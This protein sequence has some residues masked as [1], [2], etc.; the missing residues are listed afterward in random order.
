MKEKER[1]FLSLIDQGLIQVIPETGEIISYLSGKSRTLNSK[2]SNGY[3]TVSVHKR[4]MLSH[5]LVWLAVH[6]DLQTGYEINHKNGIKGDDRISN[7]E[8]VTR[9]ENV[10]HAYN[11]LGKVF[12]LFERDNHGENNGR[13]I[14]TRKDIDKMRQLFSTGNHTQIELAN[15]FGLKKSQVHNIV[16]GKQWTD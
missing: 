1:F 7:L 4:Y 13:S 3:G 12:G 14:V 2:M 9:S 16:R 6:R 15:R 5:R 8:L 11:V 10:L